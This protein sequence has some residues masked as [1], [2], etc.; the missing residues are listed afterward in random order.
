VNAK[1]RDDQVEQKIKDELKLKASV[2]DLIEMNPNDSLWILFSFVI[3]VLIFAAFNEQDLLG[4]SVIINIV[5]A[6]GFGFGFEK[7]LEVATKFSDPT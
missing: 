5:L 7:V 6:F 1:L 4:P 2:N 3:S